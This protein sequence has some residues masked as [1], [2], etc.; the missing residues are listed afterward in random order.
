MSQ[1]AGTTKQ[2]QGGGK[3]Q[4][5]QETSKRHN[6]TKTQ[7]EGTTPQGTRQTRRTQG[8]TDQWRN[9]LKL[10]ANFRSRFYRQ[11]SSSDAESGVSLKFSEVPHWES[12]HGYTIEL[13]VRGLD[14]PVRTEKLL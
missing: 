6:D 13:T 1:E 9:Q 2:K 7:K 3:R 4:T 5:G 10:A 8:D 12:Q 11:H 14:E